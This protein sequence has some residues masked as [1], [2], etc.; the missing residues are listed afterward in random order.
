MISPIQTG[1]VIAQ[2]GTNHGVMVL[3]EGPG[4]AA[5]GIG[6]PLSVQV[7]THGPR[8]AMRIQA[9]P[10]PSVGTR[11]LIMFP[12]SDIRNGVWVCSLS[13]TLNSASPFTPGFT[14]GKYEAQYS[15]LWRLDDEAGQTTTV[16]PDGSSLVVSAS[17]AVP[18][19]TRYI[20]DPTNAV[21]PK[22][23]QSFAQSTRVKSAPSAYTAVYTHASGAKLTISPA[24]AITANV[25][26]GQLFNFEQGGAT[27]SDALALVSKLV[28]AFNAHKHSGITTGSGQSGTPVTT[29]NASTIESAFINTSG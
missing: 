23:A 21:N 4:G 18:S 20:V 6:G 11:G 2:D 22:V 26:A 10:L 29:W 17:G 9:D 13:A 3:L 28:M 5:Q 7:G 8:D 15:G 27:A 19:V 14:S 1:M 24:G 12:R 25:A 16:W